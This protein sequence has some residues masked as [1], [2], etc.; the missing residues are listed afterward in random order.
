MWINPRDERAQF[1]LM[2]QTSKDSNEL[3]Q[4]HFSNYPSL[5]HI[6]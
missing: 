5:R 4:R 3:V 6:G 2:I 1:V